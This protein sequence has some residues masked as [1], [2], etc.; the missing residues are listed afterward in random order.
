MYFE[1]LPPFPAFHERELS[2]TEDG[3]HIGG[4]SRPDD[5]VAYVSEANQDLINVLTFEHADS[6][7]LL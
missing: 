7:L 1:K 3:V 4:I 2:L 6:T 5:L